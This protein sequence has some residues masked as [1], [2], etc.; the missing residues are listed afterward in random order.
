M[1]RPYKLMFTLDIIL[2]KSDI[3]RHKMAYFGMMLMLP[4]RHSF[5]PTPQYNGGS[6]NGGIDDERG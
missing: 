1:S 6:C 4:S 3:I 2:G 5:T